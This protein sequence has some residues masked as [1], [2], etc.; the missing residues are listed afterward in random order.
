VLACQRFE[1]GWAM[2]NHMSKGS[3]SV[4]R[5]TR[6]DT[7]IAQGD[8][9]AA[10]DDGIILIPTDALNS[11]FDMLEHVSSL[12]TALHPAWPLVSITDSNC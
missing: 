8:V 9:F 10:P 2:N 4:G 7:R 5:S 11:L 6:V 1:Q 12:N 3:T